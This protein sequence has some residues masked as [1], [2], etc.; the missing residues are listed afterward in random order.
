[1]QAENSQHKHPDQIPGLRHGQTDLFAGCIT[2][3]QHMQSWDSSRVGLCPLPKC[4]S[5]HVFV[6]GELKSRHQLLC[7]QGCK[8][9]WTQAS[10]L[11]HACNAKQLLIFI[12]T[13]GQVEKTP[14]CTAVLYINFTPRLDLM[15]TKAK[16]S[17]ISQ[18]TGPNPFPLGKYRA[19]SACKRNWGPAMLSSPGHTQPMGPLST[20]AFSLP[21]PPSLRVPQP[22]SVTR[23]KYFRDLAVVLS[24]CTSLLEGAEQCRKREHEL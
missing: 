23:T 21:P 19:S 6:N 8:E 11:S 3:P 1:M 10:G 9:G 7:K 2:S 4:C 17:L 18:K 14:T 12:A 5:R 13:Q 16:L 22:A 24:L 15:E 20:S